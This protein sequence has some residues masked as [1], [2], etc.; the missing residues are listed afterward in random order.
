M[1][2]DAHSQPV[3]AAPAYLCGLQ[4]RVAGA[5]CRGA[6][7][8][9]SSSPT[10]CMPLCPCAR[11]GVLDRVLHRGHTLPDKQ[12]RA[13]MEGSGGPSG[14]KCPENLKG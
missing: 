14:P 11:A 6:L 7:Q 5:G 4:G 12:V 8:P 3:P 2:S 9:H 1:P 10:T 13:Q